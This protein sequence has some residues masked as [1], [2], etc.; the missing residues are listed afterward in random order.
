MRR[1]GGKGKKKNKRQKIIRRL[2]K[3]SSGRKE[4]DKRANSQQPIAKILSILHT[5]D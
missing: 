3:K 2:E 5:P 4:K 1:N